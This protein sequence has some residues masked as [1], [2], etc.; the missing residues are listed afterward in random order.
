MTMA[1]PKVLT[2]LGTS[3]RGRKRK[4][5]RLSATGRRRLAQRV[6]A[7]RAYQALID[8]FLPQ[9]EGAGG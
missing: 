9:A 7:H 4:W 8:S 1:T 2:I 6:A 3:G 5:Y